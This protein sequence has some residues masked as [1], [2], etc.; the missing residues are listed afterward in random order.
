MSPDKETDA[1]REPDA[2]HGQPDRVQY[3]DAMGIAIWPDHQAGDDDNEEPE[4]SHDELPWSVPGTGWLAV[5]DNMR[6]PPGPWTQLLPQR[7][8]RRRCHA[9]PSSP[10]TA[11]ISV[12][13]QVTV[14][15]IEL[16]SDYD[17][18]ARA[19]KTDH[20]VLRFGRTSL[21]RDAFVVSERIRGRSEKMPE[22]AAGWM[23]AGEWRRGSGVT[24]SD[25]DSGRSSLSTLTRA[26][27]QASA[28]PWASD[29]RAVG[30]ATA[31][32]C[33]DMTSRCSARPGFV[34]PG[35]APGG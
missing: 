18:G 4:A 21:R 35:R 30:L 11:A 15:R 5:H 24:S 7:P 22:S 32:V 6:S 16:G 29:T 14:G 8:D 25:A 1:H 2:D 26:S 13:S 17:V 33:H 3:R 20:A 19:S 10:R 12:A 27:R 31:F 23:R 34:R 28:S 9:A